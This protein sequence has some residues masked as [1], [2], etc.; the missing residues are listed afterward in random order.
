MPPD[1]R[2]VIIKASFRVMGAN[3]EPDEVSTLLAITPDQSHRRGDPRSNKAG[4]PTYSPYSE[5]IWL[6]KSTPAVSDADSH[7]ADIV[8][9]LVGKEK[10]ISDLQA[11]GFR[12]DILVG[13]I[14]IE[15]NY[16][17]TISSTTVRQIGQLG[18]PVGFDLY[19]TTG[20]ENEDIPL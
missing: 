20:I 18:L 15:G 10:V 7:L 6:F 3:L 2:S 14:G 12:I 1:E 19:A 13:L 8:K 16:G 5:G 11:R 4:Y 17:Y 9:R